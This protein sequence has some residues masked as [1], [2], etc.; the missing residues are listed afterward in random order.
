VP[1]LGAGGGGW[2]R[3]TM[4]QGARV[5]SDGMD[6]S[7]FRSA[8]HASGS[9]A[10]EAEADHPTLHLWQK[11]RKDSPGPG[12]YRGGA[13][14][15]VATILYGVPSV[16]RGALPAGGQGRSRRMLVGQGLFGGYP[17]CA[18][19]GA[20]VP[21][22]NILEL[23]AKGEKNLPTSPE[24][25]LKE[26]VV[27]GEYDLFSSAQGRAPGHLYEG[28]LSA[29]GSTGGGHGYGD[30]LEREPQAVVDDVRDEIISDWAA[31]NVYRVAYDAETWTADEEKTREL[32]QH[33]RS[34]RLCQGK[35]YAEFEKEWLKKRPP[36][37]MLT[38]YGSW[39]DAK[40][41]NPIIR[42]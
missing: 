29:G 1:I 3:N 26:R 36:E 8:V 21:N 22:S 7:L 35:S 11:H 28:S 15:Y 18:T 5:N 27:D 6:S 9:D 13:T 42:I 10:E 19:P 32:R 38:Y 30:V 39:P 16:K 41:V 37:E 25:I 4:G 17:C 24:Q 12:K 20:S 33:A 14:G 34:D 23:M 40:M 2:T 31:L